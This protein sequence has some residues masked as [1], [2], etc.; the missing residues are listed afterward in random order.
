MF[1]NLAIGGNGDHLP[2]DEFAALHQSPLHSVFQA[3]TAGDLHAHDL[4]RLDVVVLDD[5]GELFGV[6]PLVQLGATNEGDMVADE[7]L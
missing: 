2:G 3:T 1:Q 7:I 4:H 5:P 6:V